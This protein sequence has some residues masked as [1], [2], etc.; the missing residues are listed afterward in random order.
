M[1]Q[2]QVIYYFKNCKFIT[3]PYQKGGEGM[4][5]LFKTKFLGTLFFGLAALLILWFANELGILEPM[6]KI[7]LNK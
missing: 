3:D 5:E 1:K 6:V 4:S 2:R 7:L